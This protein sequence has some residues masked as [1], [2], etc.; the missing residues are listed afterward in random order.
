MG[1]LL[2]LLFFITET[3]LI[4]YYYYLNVMSEAIT[5]L[6]AKLPKFAIAAL[7][8]LVFVL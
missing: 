5:D 6:I 2:L 4:N 1:V 3:K 7:T 8:D